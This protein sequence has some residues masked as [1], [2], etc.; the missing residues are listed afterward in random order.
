MS[1]LLQYN[2]HGDSEEE[3]IFPGV[4]GSSYIDDS[5]YHPNYFFEADFRGP[6]VK[7]TIYYL[8]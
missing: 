1:Y 4:G 2:L 7:D 3:R 6:E 8:R 5:D